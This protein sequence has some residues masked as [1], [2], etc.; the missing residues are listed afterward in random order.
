MTPEQRAR[1]RAADELSIELDRSINALGDLAKEA[2]HIGAP[3]LMG[4][5]LFWRLDL[6]RAL[7]RLDGRRTPR[8]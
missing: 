6:K 5:V 8:A 2:A 4:R 1:E 3:K 7:D